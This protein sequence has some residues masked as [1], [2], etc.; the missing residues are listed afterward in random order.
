MK[1]LGIYVHIPFCVKK[2]S[3]C[4]F[5][6]FANKN[7][8]IEEYVNAL[9][10]EIKDNKR[11]DYE[12]DTI[13]IGGG[14]PSFIDAKYISEIFKVIKENFNV[15][16]NAEITIEVNPGTVNEEKLQIYKEAGINRISIGLQSTKNEILEK[17]GRIH[18][19][20]QFIETY[21][22][23]RKV[24]FTNINVDLMLALPNQTITDLQESL[25]SV[26][27]LEPE[28]ISVYSLI[29]EEGT[30]MEKWVKEGNAKLPEDEIERKM[31]WM[32]KEKLEENG[33][34]HYEISNF[35]KKGFESKHN[36]NCWNQ[37]EY[38]GF[39]VSAHSY[40]N[41]RR[42]CNISNIEKYIENI[43]N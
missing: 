35:A 4:D 2:C 27:K 8:Y 21:N 12:I 1:N 43:K 22:I 13:Y 24:G 16:S 9:K 38:L 17:I 5:V 25:D 26:I 20:E 3:Y 14:T 15:N 23:A 6:S 30:L 41:G 33:Y 36:L 39:G 18:N 42:Y 11:N 10:K 34:N 37:S 31:Y 28:H 32:V 40:V 29:L 19:Y 7:D